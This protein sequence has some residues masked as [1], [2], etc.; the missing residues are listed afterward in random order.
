MSLV[1]RVL[2]VFPELVEAA[3]SQGMVRIARERGVLDARAVNIRDYTSDAHRTTDDT[4]YGGGAGMVMRAE[5]IVR[6]FRALE[7]RER[8]RTVVMG[9]RGRRFDQALARAWSEAPAVTLVCGRYK[10]VDDRILD[11][12]GAEEIS[13]G[14]F[15]LAGGELAAA[16][17]V[18]AT[19]RLL[20]GVLGDAD[21]AEEDSHEDSMLGYPV[22]TRPEEFEGHRVPEVLLSGHHANIAR[23][24]RQERLKTTWERRPDL[25]EGAALDRKDLE[26]L[27]SLAARTA[28]AGDRRGNES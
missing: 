9:A 12:L 28:K 17:M 19:A 25:L 15:V 26:F 21:S 10:G 5:P 8:G 16:A 3:L 18:E 2:T 23:W 20:P 4:P 24:R 11:I 13:I 22:Y 6:A 1:V 7:P 27:E 14:D